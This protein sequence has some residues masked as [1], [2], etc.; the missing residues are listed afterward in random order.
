MFYRRARFDAVEETAKRIL[1]EKSCFSLSDLAINGKDLLSLGLPQGK[2]I[3][4]ILNQLLDD[5]IENKTVN[6]KEALLK[7]AEKYG[8]IDDGKLW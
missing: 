1:S 6:K 8:G 3:G 2:I 5:V 4:N 7:L